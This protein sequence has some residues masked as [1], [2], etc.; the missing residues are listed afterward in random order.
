MFAA[1]ALDWFSAL[2]LSPGVLSPRAKKEI[3]SYYTDLLEPGSRSQPPK[4]LNPVVG[5]V[6]TPPLVQLVGGEEAGRAILGCPGPAPHV[7]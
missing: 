7:C 5:N 1:M 4:M 3:G 6:A 2:Q